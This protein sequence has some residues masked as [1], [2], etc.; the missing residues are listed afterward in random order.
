M[1]VPLVSVLILHDSSTVFLKEEARSGGNARSRG[2]GGGGGGQKRGGEKIRE[3]AEDESVL[4]GNI[5][6]VVGRKR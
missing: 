5:T 1:R 4:V 3:T 2:G 6:G